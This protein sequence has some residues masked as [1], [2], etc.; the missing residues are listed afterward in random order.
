MCAL[1]LSCQ[2]VSLTSE[3]ATD[4]L[5]AIGAGSRRA[6]G[7]KDW[8]DIWTD[9]EELVEV[10]AQIEQLKLEGLKIQESDDATLQK[11]CRPVLHC[12]GGARG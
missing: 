10:K 6:V 3:I 11:E 1:V 4:M 12:S 2:L 5:E 7:K 9:S 8:A